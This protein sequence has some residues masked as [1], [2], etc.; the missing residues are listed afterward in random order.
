VPIKVT[1]LNPDETSVG[2]TLDDEIRVQLS[3]GP[4][5]TA[6]VVFMILDE[7][8][9]LL[10]KLPATQDTTFSDQY[11]RPDINKLGLNSTQVYAVVAVA[12]VLSGGAINASGGGA[13]YANKL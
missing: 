3:G 10:H 4:R 6:V 8:E 13:I 7:N 12:K 9:G 11:F 2:P 5:T 1:F